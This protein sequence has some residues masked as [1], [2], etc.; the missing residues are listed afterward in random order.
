MNTYETPG[1]R[2]DF[3]KLP[4]TIQEQ[5]IKQLSVLL[6]NPRYPS[7]RIKKMSGEA[8]RRGIWEGRIT[9]GYRFT[10]TIS[11]QIFILRRVGTHDILNR[12]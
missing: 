5:T 6:T 2:K 11:R 1:F 8:G 9:R 4:E 12:P 10:F 7:L 3:R